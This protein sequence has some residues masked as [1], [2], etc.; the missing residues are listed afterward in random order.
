MKSKLT[1]RLTIISFMV[2]SAAQ[3]QLMT[4]DNVN[5]T[6]TGSAQL[7][8]QGDIQNQNGTLISNSGT[9]DL[10]GNWIH[11]AA[12][13][14]FGIST[15]T[16]VL[17]GSN[18]SIGGNNSTTFNNLTLQG[19]GVKTLNQNITVGGG[20][21]TPSGLLNL[22]SFNL[23]L[24]SKTLTVSNP[25]T[26]AISRTSG[27]I[28]SETNPLSGYGSIKWN[29]GMAAAGSN[30]E[31]PFGSATSSIYN[32]V[33]FNVTTAGTV[34]T[35]QGSFNIGSVSIATYP[36]VTSA[37]PNNRPLPTGVTN[38]LN[39]FGTEN[40]SKTIDRYWIFDV[41]GF[42]TKPVSTLTLSYLDKEHDLT[43]SSTNNIS[44]A[45]LK[46]QNWD[47]TK[48]IQPQVGTIDVNTNK[49][50]ITG[51]SNYNSVWTFAGTESPLPVEL[52]NFDA[53]LNADI[54]TDLSWST[55]SEINNDYFEI[56]KSSDSKNFN[57]MQKVEGG[58]NS[59]T[60]LFYKTLDPNP[61]NGITY[62]RLKQFDYNGSYTYSAIKSVKT[63][64]AITSNINVFPNPFSV[65]T[66][67]QF[68]DLSKVKNNATIS[69]YSSTGQIVFTSP[70]N[71]MKKINDNTLTFERRNLSPGLYQ[72][73]IYAE[74][75][76]SFS[77]KLVVE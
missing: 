27:F 51:V 42:A 21:T 33:N 36:T 1:Y 28:V 11:N 10:S 16:V 35:G 55:A 31:F 15:G 14:C 13:N 2:W 39:I 71:Q 40:A 52:L 18:Q 17:N 6:I 77:G 8:V 66:Y 48:W 56:E 74:G 41:Q 76:A 3:A 22:S 19:S 43:G 29:I 9:I 69:V 60:P 37:T 64:N 47:G 24:N 54:Q 62:Y 5:I 58:G 45:S 59:T 34:I 46:A 32:P 25:L 73:V 72:Y 70:L 49:M 23:D 61:Y 53:R 75:S 12:N 63:E 4:N 65:Q 50:T 68:D 67:F 38:L 7:T 57:F 26:T 44:E 30:Y 20:N